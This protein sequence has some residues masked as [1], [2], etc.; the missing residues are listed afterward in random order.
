[1][2]AVIWATKD[3]D[4]YF[5]T[6]HYQKFPLKLEI[7]T[8]QQNLCAQN[9]RKQ[10][11]QQRP[12][13]NRCSGLWA[14][15]EEH[16]FVPAS[17]TRTPSSSTYQPQK[18]DDVTGMR[19]LSGILQTSPSIPFFA[20]TSR[21]SFAKEPVLQQDPTEMLGEGGGEGGM[22][23]E[24]RLWA[25]TRIHAHTTSICPSTSRHWAA[26]KGLMQCTHS[27]PPVLFLVHF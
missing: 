19:K 21:V 5:K 16:S 11:A 7:T 10:Q 8:E 18:R 14:P 24:A 4:I 27:P 17:Q 13:R 15:W 23:K 3:S 26:M 20:F 25:R 2:I 22:E 1:M 12:R 9:I 6:S